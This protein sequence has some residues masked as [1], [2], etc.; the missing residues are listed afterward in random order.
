MATMENITEQFRSGA[1]VSSVSRSRGYTRWIVVAIIVI[2]VAFTAVGINS[3]VPA[4]APQATDVPPVTLPV[5]DPASPVYS[6][7]QTTPL[8]LSDYELAVGEGRYA[9]RNGREYWLIEEKDTN[10]WF[11]LPLPNGWH[12]LGQSIRDEWVLDQYQDTFGPLDKYT[13]SHEEQR[14]EYVR[15]LG[16]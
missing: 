8:L 13:M 3:Y 12:E 6:E 11:L 7:P 15:T 2:V 16:E 14:Q 9:K 10:L 1:H 4:G 5:T